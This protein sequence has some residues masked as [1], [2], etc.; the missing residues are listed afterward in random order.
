MSTF[1]EDELVYHSWPPRQVGGQHGGTPR[2]GVLAVHVRT[3]IG[4]MCMD[5]RSQLRNRER[6]VAMLRAL[7]ESGEPLTLSGSAAPETL[8]Q[9]K[10]VAREMPVLTAA[11]AQRADHDSLFIKFE[12]LERI[13]NSVSEGNY[14]TNRKMRE[15]RQVV[16]LIRAQVLK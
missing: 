11:S 2:Q 12:Q 3:G 15:A 14:Q 1:E 5:E 13:L 6:A 4:A 7:V 8:E 16:D 10:S 9:L